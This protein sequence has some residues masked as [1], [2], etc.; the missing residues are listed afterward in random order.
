MKPAP[1][2]AARRRLL[3]HHH[4]PEGRTS[5]SS[6]ATIETKALVGDR[7]GYRFAKDLPS[8]QVPA[9]VQKTVLA[10]RIDRL[11]PEESIAVR[12]PPLSVWAGRIRQGS[13]PL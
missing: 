5:R 4:S 3:P 2:P 12:T 10:A 8:V 1:R 6:P 9:T 11:P 13:A 7:G